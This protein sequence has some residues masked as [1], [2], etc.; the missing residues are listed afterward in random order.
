[1]RQLNLT[2][3]AI[4]SFGSFLLLAVGLGQTA[5]A[6]YPSTVLSQNP[7][8]FY[9]LNETIKPNFTHVTNSGSLG[10]AADGYYT[11][12]P[13]FNLPGPFTGSSAVGFDGTSQYAYTPWVSGLNTSTFSFEIWANPA[14]VPKFD[15]M[16][17]SAELNSPR[18]G[19][20]FAQDDGSTF[21]F[22]SAWVVRFFNTNSSTPSVTLH[23]TNATAGVWTHL[24]IT[25]DGTTAKMYTN[26]VV[27]DT[28]T[29]TANSAGVNYVPNIDAPFTIGVRSNIQFEWPG[30]VAEAAIY[31]AALSAARVA[32]HYTAA[33]TAPTTYSSTVLAD[34]PLLYDQFKAPATAVATNSGTLGT[35]YN[36][37]YLADEKISFANPK[38]LP[39]PQRYSG[40]HVT[41]HLP[42]LFVGLAY[43]FKGQIPQRVT[44]MTIEK[45]QRHGRRRA[46]GKAGRQSQ[47]H[48]RAV[49]LLN[50]IIRLQVVEGPGRP[51][52]FDERSMEWVG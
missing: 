51:D 40:D 44:Q 13:S 34:S 15:Y 10:T 52:T 9:R 37:L 12:L 49:F 5:K 19:W 4:L 11:N 3:N 16:A 22:G 38:R 26:G 42:Q 31:P 8:A 43:V 39:L 32:A 23:A 46:G 29:P 47:G 7:A 33:T 24:V 6:D 41:I 17:S 30:D 36:G 25:F 14:V 2:K 18:S 1:M 21:G 35:S 27:A 28:E 45:N 20:Y 50:S 48:F